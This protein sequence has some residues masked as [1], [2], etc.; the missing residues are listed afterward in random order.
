MHLKLLKK[1]TQI[2]QKMRNQLFLIAALML[3]SCLT[4]TT[5]YAQKTSLNNAQ[6]GIKGELTFLTCIQKM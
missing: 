3:L 1:S 4:C 6:L 2:K 5:C